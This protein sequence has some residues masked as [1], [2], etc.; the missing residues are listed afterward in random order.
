[1]SALDARCK[2]SFDRQGLMT[3]FGARLVEAAEGRAV[4]EVPYREDLTQQH[5]YFH[6]GVVAAIADNAC[7]YAAYTTMPADSSVLTVEFKINLM[8]PA[9]GDLLRAEARVCKAGRTLVVAAATVEVIRDGK[10][11]TCGEMLGT[12]IV[13][14][15][16]SDVGQRVL[17]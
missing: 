7:G 17:T 11:V 14:R 15:H 16:T 5:G 9:A 10:A 13:L 3:L 1:V 6:G 4:I 12:F 2:E 8:N